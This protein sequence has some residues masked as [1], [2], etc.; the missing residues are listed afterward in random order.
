MSTQ[1]VLTGQYHQAGRRRIAEG[2]GVLLFSPTRTTAVPRTERRGGILSWNSYTVHPSSSRSSFS[3][4]DGSSAIDAIFKRNPS[5]GV[6]IQHFLP[7]H[8]GR[9]NTFFHL[10]AS[11]LQHASKGYWITCG[12]NVTGNVLVLFI[13]YYF[14][15]GYICNL[16]KGCF[17]D[18]DSTAV[19]GNWEPQPESVLPLQPSVASADCEVRAD[20]NSEVGFSIYPLQSDAWSFE[21][22]GLT[23]CTLW[24]L[25]IVVFEFVS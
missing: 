23:I 17:V 1:P 22:Y 4:W 25:L 9:L 11:G 2:S 12:L 14:T 20:P 15:Q 16:F 3:W 6:V 24:C 5:G 18:Y 10:H 7:S 21:I 13:I 19:S 8:R